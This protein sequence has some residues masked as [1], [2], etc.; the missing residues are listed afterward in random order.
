M[1]Q[2]DYLENKIDKEYNSFLGVPEKIKEIK[3]NSLYEI[4]YKDYFK[5]N[6]QKIKIQGQINPQI[7]QDNIIRGSIQDING[8]KSYVLE[9]IGKKKL[10]EYISKTPANER[11]KTMN[12]TDY[13]CFYKYI[14]PIDDT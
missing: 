1:T 13:G 7:I 10:E 14:D 6:E 8:K 12:A 2:K 9:I 5:L 4:T 11:F 3:K